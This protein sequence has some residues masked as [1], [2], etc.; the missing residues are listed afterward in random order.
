MS[1]ICI[2]HHRKTIGVRTK[3]KM[4]H[5]FLRCA[6]ADINPFVMV[7]TLAKAAATEA[8]EKPPHS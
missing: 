6:D 3:G 2:I 4:P 1:L 5:S 7:R 8:K